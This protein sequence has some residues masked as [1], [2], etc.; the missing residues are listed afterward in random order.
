MG[1]PPGKKKKNL[2][3][4]NGTESKHPRSNEH[5]PKVFGEGTTI[6]LDMA[7]DMKEEGNKLFKKRD[8]EGAL[9]KYENAIKLLPKNHIDT[10][11]LH[12][13]TATC[14]MQ[15]EPKQYHRAI[16]ECNQALEASP[17][18][19]KALLKRA[20]C[21]EALSRLDLACKDVDAILSLEP[22]NITALD[23]SERVKKVMEKKGF[24]LDDNEDLSLTE[25]VAV[26]EKLKKKKKKKKKMKKKKSHKAEEKVIIEEKHIDVKEQP[27]WVVKL[28]F[29]ED[30]RWA[31]IPANCSMLRLRETVGRK[32][33]S[34]KAIL[35]KY[36]DREGD[37]VT[38]TTSEELTWARQSAEPQGSVRLY[39]TEVSPECEPWFEDAESNSSSTM[40]GRNHNVD[41]EYQNIMNDEEK[42]SPAYVDDWIIQ[43]AHLFKNH[44]GFSSD[45]YLN[46]HELGM[47]LSSEAIE[48][49]ITSEEAQDIF[50][51]AEG[52][53][54]VMAALALFNWG[55][56]HLSRARKELY[57]SEDA[58]KESILEKMEDAYEWAQDEY[59]KAGKRY[60]DALKIKP[61]FYEGF[62]ALG[63]QQFE[64]AKLSWCHVI[65]SK[66]DLEAWPSEKLT[67]LF[68]NAEDNMEKGT[69]MWEKM[70]EQR[71]KEL[72]ELKDDKSLLEKMGLDGCFK[73]LSVDETAEQAT[74]MSSR[75]NR[76]W[77]TILYERSVVEFKLGIPIW[78]EFLAAAVEKFKLAGVSPV[79]IAVITE[80]HCANRTSQEGKYF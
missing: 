34:L 64:R 42:S 31:Q 79:N 55:N 47:K 2:G 69:K 28:V 35:I 53:F 5:N 36:R 15:M 6:F 41:A 22:N 61:D 57:L 77:G 24:M 65:G 3:G 54:Q 75:I 51:L 44:L 16:R 13:N 25:V 49:T 1:K 76:I 7:H 46:L 60:Q 68:N 17:K 37:M 33:P 50:E 72:S 27:M 70:E 21:F 29:A 67:E 73:D 4:K 43:F 48:D 71:I 20:R 52:N 11:H 40:Q 38:I 23:I 62:L 66:V 32:F 58:S 12:S 39:L 18:Y 10:A 74:N 59:I 19:I 63:L 45:S 56:I 8:Y 80:N 30:I 14:Y 9:L 78:K 26:K